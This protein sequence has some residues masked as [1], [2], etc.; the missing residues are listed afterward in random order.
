M[1]FKDFL[2]LYCNRSDAMQTFWN[3]YLLVALG[4]LGFVVTAKAG[5]RTTLGA[6]ILSL[7]FAL[8]AFTNAGGLLQAVKQRRSASDAVKDSAMSLKNHPEYPQVQLILQYI[9]SP[10]PSQVLVTH[11]VA[12]LLI[13]AAIWIVTLW[14]PG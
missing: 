13:F 7:G 11:T 9:E 10:T 14:H 4:V 3:F 5:E 2:D 6:A 1:E 12:D 8:F